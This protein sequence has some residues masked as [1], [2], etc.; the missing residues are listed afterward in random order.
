MLDSVLSHYNL[1]PR[2]H[3]ARLRILYHRQ[4]HTFSIFLRN[5]KKMPK[6]AS[7]FA[8]LLNVEVTCS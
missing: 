4:Q 1:N 7:A 6:N 5:H 2:I 8:K 3:E